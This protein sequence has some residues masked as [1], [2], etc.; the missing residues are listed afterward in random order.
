MWITGIVRNDRFDE[1][2][3][4]DLLAD[5]IGQ[6]TRIGSSTGLWPDESARLLNSVQE[7]AVHRT[8]LGIP[9]VLHE[10]SVA[11]FTHRGA[12]VFPQALGLAATWDPGLVEEVAEVIRAQMLGTGARMALAPVLDVARD[13]RWGRVEETYGESPELC[14]R[15]GVAYVRGLQGPDLAG[16]VICAAKHFLG[17]AAAAGGRNQAPV[18]LG[19]REPRD[20]QAAPFA[21]VDHR[22]RTGRDDELLL[23]GR[24]AALR[25]RS[26]DPDRPAPR[27]AR[28]RRPWWWPTTS[29]S[30]SSLE[31]HRMAADAAEAA[32]LA[33]AASTSSCRHSTATATGPTWFARG[34][35]AIG[36]RHRRRAG[37][38]RSSPSGCSSAPWSTRR[39]GPPT[40]TRTSG[41]WPAGP[42]GGA[43]AC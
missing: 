26:G 37:A 5:G 40:T 21:A 4:A 30:S 38:C 25:R 3:A 29:P 10:E 34:A 22:G 6:V 11:G 16:G 14:S 27:R 12:T 33:L 7:F 24:R 18:H 23:V 13:P 2:A 28:L 20:V 39:C 35:C 32:A 43:S 31:H 36:G 1:A 9:V 41:P 15:M 42:P 17:Y 19:P 8:R